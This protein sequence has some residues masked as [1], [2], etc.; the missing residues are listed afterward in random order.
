MD[1]HVRDA[2]A[3]AAISIVIAQ[4]LSLLQLTHPVFSTN[5]HEHLGP[6]SRALSH[7]AQSMGSASSKLTAKM[8][9]HGDS[10]SASVDK[11]IDSLLVDH[12]V[13]V[14]SKSYCPYCHM[15][16]DAIK[17]A[18]ASVP[19]FDG[20]EVVE[21]DMRGDGSAIQRA[22]AARTGRTTVPS[23]YVAGK[24]IGGGSETSALQRQGK[25]A[26]LIRAAVSKAQATKSTAST[27]T[28]TATESTSDAPLRAGSDFGAYIDGI[29]KSN[30]VVVF[31]KTF[32]PYCKSAKAA[33]A[34]SGAKVD[35][36][37]GPTVIELDEHEFGAEIQEKLAEKTGRRSVPNVFVGGVNVG[38]GDDTA[39]LNESGVLAQMIRSAPEKRAAAETESAASETLASTS[40]VQSGEKLITFGAGCF[41]GL[42]LA[43]QRQDGVLRTEVGFSNGNFSPVSY[44][45]VCTG[46][47]GH[48]E[49]VRVWY[50]PAEVE[51]ATLIALW[52]SRHDVTSLNKQ[53][54]DRGTQYR[55]ALFWSD[56]AGKDS[57][58]EWHSSQLAKGVKVVTDVGKEDGYTAAEPYHQK[59]LEGRGQDASKGAKQRIR[60]YG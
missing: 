38:G 33:I 52:E 25:L 23:V 44:D 36:F 20:P 2:V 34:A 32:C 7:H 53:G 18:G 45:A 17:E 28:T 13:V 48:A 11:L 41:W 55:S 26:D 21:L 50:D 12:P 19:A 51:L 22:I 3:V 31:G 9:G 6:Q 29:V 27:T 5:L 14:F 30:D 47:S 43:F 8:A 54:N 49:V 40:D 15:A 16:K 60:C 4:T 24:S 42:E 57:A 37:A 58:T 39:G 56:D 10:S 35:G 1:G 59:Y 46:K